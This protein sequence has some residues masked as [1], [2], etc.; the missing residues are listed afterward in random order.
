[1]ENENGSLKIPREFDMWAYDK[2]PRAARDA[3]KRTV[4]NHASPP[5]LT[6]ARAGAA[7]DQIRFEIQRLDAVHLMK[8]DPEP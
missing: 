6:L 5:Y 4:F 1:M 3:L 8:K 7:P 2:L